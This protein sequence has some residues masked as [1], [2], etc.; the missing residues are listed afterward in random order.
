MKLANP[1]TVIPAGAEYADSVMIFYYQNI[2]RL[3]GPHIS[4]Q[5]WRDILSAEDE[6][7]KN[8]VVCRGRMPVAW[9]RVNGLM[10]TDTAWISM[11]VVSDQHQRQGVGR[12]AVAFAEDYVRQKGFRQIAIHTT[13]DN[14]PA[15]HLY[16]QCGYEVAGH[17]VC[18]MGDGVRCGEYTFVKT[19]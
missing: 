9:L 17:E 1:Y 3:H 16:H 5:E 4:L 14:L 12:Y 15:Q 7:E 2:E 18:E 6:D 19:L 11:L 10:N 8:F 13:E